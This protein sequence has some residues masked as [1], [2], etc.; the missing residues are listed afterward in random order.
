MG[1]GWQEADTKFT[2]YQHHPLH[3][4]KLSTGFYWSHDPQFIQAMYSKLVMQEFL[5]YHTSQVQYIPLEP[6]QL[7]CF[8]R[9]MII[10]WTL[11]FYAELHLQYKYVAEQVIIIIVCVSHPTNPKSLSIYLFAKSRLGS[12]KS[13][14]GCIIAWKI[15]K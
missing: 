12:A 4:S 8:L 2:W 6:Q 10:Y 3:T 13:L 1:L 9:K 5:Y 11:R 7:R 15:K 14:D